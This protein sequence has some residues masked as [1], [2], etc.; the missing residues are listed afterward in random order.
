MV[1]AD[2]HQGEDPEGSYEFRVDTGGG[3][4]E[5]GRSGVEATDAVRREDEEYGRRVAGNAKRQDRDKVGTGNGRVRRL[6]RGD[7]LG[8]TLAKMRIALFTRLLVPFVAKGV[9]ERRR[10]GRTDVGQRT[11]Y[12]SDD[13]APPQMRCD[14]TYVARLQAIRDASGAGSLGFLGFTSCRH[15]VFQYP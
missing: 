7:A 2:G 6:D 3:E 4:L 12:G 1:H 15:E 14:T 10:E 13:R 5:H 8:R 9:T 11:D